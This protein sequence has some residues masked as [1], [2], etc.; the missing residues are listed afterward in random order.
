MRNNGS[1]ITAQFPRNLSR[2][3]N[4]FLS[5]VERGAFMLYKEP[6]VRHGNRPRQAL[7]GQ[8]RP[9]CYRKCTY[10]T[11]GLGGPL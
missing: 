4:G 11:G 7:G 10:R 2:N 3:E 1:I 9:V 5:D 8:K 6:G